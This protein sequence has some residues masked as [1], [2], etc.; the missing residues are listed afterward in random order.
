MYVRNGLSSLRA[1]PINTSESCPLPKYRRW[2][3]IIK[4][5]EQIKIKVSLIIIINSQPIKPHLQKLVHKHTVYWFECDNTDFG[6]DSL[7]AIDDRLGHFTL[8]THSREYSTRKPCKVEKN[9]KNQEHTHTHTRLITIAES[10]WKRARGKDERFKGWAKCFEWQNDFLVLP[11]SRWFEILDCVT[12][13][14][15]WKK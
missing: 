1:Q 14:L 9:I 13:C 8:Q 10:S 7:T 5:N 12:G 15:F 6:P 11:S 3:L 4:I 2:L